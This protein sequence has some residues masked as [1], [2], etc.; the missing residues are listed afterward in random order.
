MGLV[1]CAGTDS[2]FINKDNPRVRLVNATSVDG[3]IDAFI[4]DE[5]IA[6]ELGFGAI[7]NE[8]IQT[9]GNHR[10]IVKSSGAAGTTLANTETTWELGEWYTVIAYTDNNGNVKLVNTRDN[11]EQTPGKQEVRVVRGTN[12]YGDVDIYIYPQGTALPANPTWT[13]NAI[14]ESTPQVALNPGNYTLRIFRSGERE[15]GFV[16]EDIVVTAE[17][18]LVYIFARDQ[19][20]RDRL[21]SYNE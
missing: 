17:R 2:P 19:L 9:N 6:N 20:G 10:T 8:S 21:L 16:T 12:F 7:S 14:G 18:N 3:S 4:D 15:D 5:K 13:L 1:G 11:K